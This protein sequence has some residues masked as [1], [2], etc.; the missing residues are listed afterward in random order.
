MSIRTAKVIISNEAR[1]LRQMRIGKGLSMRAAGALV[2]RSDSF[3][4]QIENGR[5]EVPKGEMLEALV[6]VYGPIKVAS[7]KERA[8]LFKESY[9]P[10]EEAQSLLKRLS[11][12]QTRLAL[13]FLQA[14]LCNRTY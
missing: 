1:V 3:I 7:F 12:D 4:S 8:R 9:S 13:A 5:M 10:K 6:T 11:D 14:M 2:G